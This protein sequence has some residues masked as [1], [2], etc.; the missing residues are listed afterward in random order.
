MWKLHVLPECTHCLRLPLFVRHWEFETL[1]S[2]SS[3][4][5]PTVRPFSCHPLLHSG[6]TLKLS[7]KWPTHRLSPPFSLPLPLINCQSW[8]F[9]PSSPPLPP[10]LAQWKEK[11][12]PVSGCGGGG[13][14]EKRRLALFF[15]ALFL[16]RPKSE[17]NEDDDRGKPLYVLLFSSPP[18]PG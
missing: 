15:F 7:R 3:S 9:L 13:E 2:S 14:K 8:V 16:P 18:S 12:S 4:L 5:L 10:F 11:Q 17:E 6:E 1:S